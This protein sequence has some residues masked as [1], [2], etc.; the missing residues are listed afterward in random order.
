MVILNNNENHYQL[1]PKYLV[2]DLQAIQKLLICSRFRCCA[3]GV[4]ENQ[5]TLA[6]QRKQIFRPSG[7]TDFVALMPHSIPPTEGQN[8]ENFTKIRKRIHLS[9]LNSRSLFFLESK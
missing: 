3:F 1:T 8:Y 7:K 9:N 5:K 6:L 2:F 4:S